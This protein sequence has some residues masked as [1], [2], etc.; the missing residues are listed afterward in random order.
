MS[1]TSEQKILY[2]EVY[3][4]AWATWNGTAW[5]NVRLFPDVTTAQ[6][7]TYATHGDKTKVINNLGLAVSSSLYSFVNGIYK[8]DIEFSMKYR[9]DLSSRLQDLKEG[10]YIR[11]YNGDGTVTQLSEP[12]FNIEDTENT[13]DATHDVMSFKGT[14]YIQVSN[15]TGC[16]LYLNDYVYLGS[17][18]FYTFKNKATLIEDKDV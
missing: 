18:I 6:N 8:I 14:Q 17:S 13:V 3:P 16:S 5:T 10:A 2:V 4:K 12:A 1:Y 9:T 11:K 15:S 7:N